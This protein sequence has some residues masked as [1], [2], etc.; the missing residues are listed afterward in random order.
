M[1]TS[2]LEPKTAPAD[3]NPSPLPP[4][5]SDPGRRLRIAGVAAL[6][7]GTAALY[8]WGLSASGYANSFYS[9]AVQ[10]GSQSWKAFFFGS[11]DA[12][13]AITVDKPPASLWLMALSVRIFGLSS[14]SILVPQALLGVATVGVLYASVRRTLRARGRA[15]GRC[16][17]RPDPGGGADVPLQQPR[18]AAGLPDDGGGVPHPAGGREGERAPAGRCR[19]AD[20]LR[21][22][23]EDAAGL[24]GAA[25]LRPG[26]PDRRA[27]DRLRKRLLHLLAAFG[28][29]DRLARLV[30]RHRRTRARLLASLRRRL[31]EQLGP[32]SDLRLQRPRPD[33][34]PGRRCRRRAGRHVRGAERHPAVRAESPAA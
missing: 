29:H 11:L 6:L 8:L 1:A 2:T 4:A 15:A 27:D 33:L 18:C 17:P 7:V 21:V 26:V 23:D 16:D 25:G 28:A 13:N 34:R 12:G 30:G 14:W 5:S 32:R 24:P 10:A 3:L 20:R 31:G 22:P 9:A 19:C